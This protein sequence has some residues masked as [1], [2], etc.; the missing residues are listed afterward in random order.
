MN[1][2]ES[3]RPADTGAIRGTPS[4]QAAVGSDGDDRTVIGG[5]ADGGGSWRQCRRAVT[6][7]DAGP[8]RQASRKA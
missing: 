4:R 2:E 5:T 8:D 6:V 7:Q 3:K 1:G